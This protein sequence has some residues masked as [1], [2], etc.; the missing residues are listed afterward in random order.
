MSRHCRVKGCERS[1]RHR[2]NTYCE[3]HAKRRQRGQ[4]L[5]APAAPA[6]FRSLK[7]MLAHFAG[8]LLKADSP[9][10]QRR[11][12]WAFENQIRRRERAAISR[13]LAF[14]IGDP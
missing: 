11:V 12:H 8:R 4:P 7:K 13:A 5:D 9:E 14:L 6:P 10:E 1:L 3:M 2:G